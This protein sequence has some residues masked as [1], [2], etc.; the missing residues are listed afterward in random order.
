MISPPWQTITK[1]AVGS[2]ALLCAVPTVA[3]EKDDLC[4][5]L[6]ADASAYL[7]ATGGPVISV[8]VI[9]K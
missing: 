8:V 1:I 3:E 7:A 2:R 9:E 4:H 6:A 5:W